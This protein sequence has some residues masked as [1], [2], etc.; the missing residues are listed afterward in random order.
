MLVVPIGY[1]YF[2]ILCPISISFLLPSQR[3]SEARVPLTKVICLYNNFLTVFTSQN[4][5]GGASL[6]FLSFTAILSIN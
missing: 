5:G 1:V 3:I 6:S 4:G 2:I